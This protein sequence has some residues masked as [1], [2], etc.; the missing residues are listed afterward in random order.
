MS[1]T[2]FAPTRIR[3]HLRAP[4][5]RAG[6]AL[7]AS[8]VA[9]SALGAVYWFVAARRFDAEAVGIGSALVAATT[10][11]AGVANLGL[12]NGLI[13]FVPTAGEDT[14]RLVARSYLLSAVCAVLSGAIFLVGLN[15]WAPKLSFLR[16]N[17]WSVT[18]FV[19]TLAAWSIFVLQDSVLVG[20]G[21]AGWVPVENIVF[22]LVKIVALLSLVG[23]SSRWS[24]FLSW[25]V[26]T[27]AL[28]AVVNWAMVR[29][30]LPEHEDR[31]VHRSP[32]SFGTVMRF[33]LADHVASLFWLATLDGLP[34]LVLGRSG[35]AS[36]A[37]YFL[38]AQIAYGLYVMSGCIGAAL[39]AEAVREPGR[40][41]D[42]NRRAV[43]QAFG[44]VVPAT[45]AVI[46]AAPWLLRIF[47]EEYALNATPLLRLLAL[48]AVPYT[49]ISIAL[50]RARVR[51]DMRTV[52]GGHGAIFVLCV[53]FAAVFENHFGLVGVGAGM[54]LGQS[55]VAVAMLAIAV[56]RAPQTWMVLVAEALGD[57]VN[58]ARHLRASVGLDERLMALGL[59]L[60]GSGP[61]RLLSAMNDVTVAR[62]PDFGGRGPVVVKMAGR[63]RAGRAL[64]DH[65]NALRAVLADPALRPMA[66]AFPLLISEGAGNGERYVVES[67][68]PGTATS[69]ALLDPTRRPAAFAA[70]G[71]FMAELSNRTA[72]QVIVDDDLFHEWVGGPLATIAGVVGDR[73]DR[74]ASGLHHL[75]AEFRS[76][77]VGRAVSVSRIHGDLTPGNI[78]LSDRGDTVTGLVD[79]ECSTPNGIPG[80]DSATFL[81]AMRRERT[82]LELGRIVLDVAGPG[83]PPD[84]T[85]DPDEA[86]FWAA[87][88]TAGPSLSIRH[89][90]LLAWLAH[91]GSNLTKCE[92]Y[93]RNPRWLRRNVISVLE[94]L[95]FRAD[96]TGASEPSVAAGGVD[97]AKRVA[98]PLSILRSVCE[99]L[100]GLATVGTLT[101]AVALWW[102]ALRRIDVRTMTDLGLVSVVP[103]FAWVAIGAVALAFVH[104]VT[105]PVLPERRLAVLLVGYLVMIHAAAPV[106]Y[107]TLRYSWAWKHIG[108]VDY[109]QRTGSVNPRIGPLDVYHNWPGFF[110][111]N[112]ALVDLIGVKNAVVFA[113]WAPVIVNLLNL[114]ALL[115][116]LP[117][118]VAD[119]RVVWTAA[120]LFFLGNW[121]GQDYF[122]PQALA[123]FLYLVLLA[124]LLRRFRNGEGVKGTH[125]EKGTHRIGAGFV[126]L[127][128][129]M[130]VISSHQL[131]P[132]LML[133]VVALLVLTRRIRAT[134]WAVLAVAGQG[135]WLLG[136]ARVFTSEHL[137]SLL[138]SF[139][140]PVENAGAT[141][142][143]TG[144][145]SS[146]QALVSLSGRAVV[147]FVAA[148]A[149]A[150]FVVRLRRGHRDGT[151]LILLCSPALLV[152]AN[153]FGGEI[154]FR[155]FLF[156]VP[157]L[158]L[159]AAW[160]IL[161]SPSSV[162]GRIRMGALACVSFVLMT[163]FVF[164]H[165]G[166]DRQYHFSK[167]EIAASTFLATNAVAPTLLVEGS[168]NYP[169]RFLNYDRFVYVPITL[170]PLDSVRTLLV[171][172]A[173]R[174]SQW[175]AEPRYARAYVLITSSQKADVA[176]GGPIPSDALDRV[177]RS[178]RAS[179]KFAIAFENR[180]AVI[181]TLAGSGAGP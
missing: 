156:S 67:C 55:L 109:I 31:R 75:E 21:R 83:D 112:A 93:R 63:R 56:L 57:T 86:A 74:V 167:E 66:P 41:A 96:S 150:G 145:Q 115:F 127:S 161:P 117:T 166:K 76:L 44:L 121:V 108:I 12:K 155:A 23:L 174:L 73:S 68:L 10:L 52:I 30:L 81:L 180:D 89:L 15:V 168:G 130:T 148:L 105:R 160:A 176:A 144:E 2:W 53:G 71:S 20:I 175:L 120:W 136:P 16:E 179:P 143:N 4:V 17:V 19:A 54:L 42:L 98:R 152:M 171:N 92:R 113:V 129:A 103:P 29:Y 163:G 61:A 33:S 124:L 51:Q 38:S 3:A 37:Y 165:F 60:E 22:S 134:W 58:K 7:I 14:G 45:T 8:S 142:R 99:P 34:L 87:T 25:G 147:V 9:T 104:A 173:D 80:V 141:I 26:P 106:K 119:R 149:V 101:G 139:G 32:V 164:A 88:S 107:E 137:T 140:A 116:L 177:E 135:L 94:G 154:L 110:S 50:S 133:A 27:L 97:N 48:S 122:A 146:G 126:A 114:A 158:S 43:V 65:V 78:L 70:V 178:L 123:Y 84:D 181:F 90:A 77:L 153:E 131:T 72:R 111:A 79:W 159:F 6:Y 138:E 11:L 13:R 39:V 91:V 47:G 24:V 151:V 125:G 5:V 170:E 169:G 100:G 162:P 85:P 102:W 1:I 172:P 95:T 28:I 36:A 157:F 64:T 49:G 128:F 46:V 35:A 69:S 132:A 118:F 18:V 59:P 40:L 62:L 82:G